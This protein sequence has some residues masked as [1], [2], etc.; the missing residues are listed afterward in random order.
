[1]RVGTQQKES[2]KYYYLLMKAF[3]EET[4]VER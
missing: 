1:M 4:S 3:K 2:G